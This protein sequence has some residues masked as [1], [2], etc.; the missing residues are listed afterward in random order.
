M[1][2]YYVEIDVA[3]NPA[4]AG[5]QVDPFGRTEFDA[6]L[7]ICLA[8][9]NFYLRGNWSLSANWTPAVN[10][11]C[12]LRAWD[13]PTPYRINGGTLY[14]VGDSS[15]LIWHEGIVY[16]DNFQA[17]QIAADMF[18]NCTDFSAQFGITDRNT[19]IF[20]TTGS[21]A[22]APVTN[23]CAIFNTGVGTIS[24]P[25]ATQFTNSVTNVAN[26]AALF[27]F[28]GNVASEAGSLYSQSYLPAPAWDNADL[29]AFDIAD[30]FGVGNRNGGWAFQAIWVDIRTN[31]DGGAPRTGSKG[32]PLSWA[33]YVAFTAERTNSVFRIYGERTLTV[34]ASPAIDADDTVHNGWNGNVDEGFDA[35]KIISASSTQIGFTLYDESTVFRRLAVQG[36][37]IAMNADGTGRTYDWKNCYFRSTVYSG[38]G[39]GVEGIYIST[40][41]GDIPT[42]VNFEGCTFKSPLVS[43]SN[44]SSETYFKYCLFEDSIIATSNLAQELI[45]DNCVFVGKTQAEVEARIGSGVTATFISCTFGAVLNRTLPEIT[46]I[47]S[48]SLRFSRFGLPAISSSTW[49]SDDYNHGF[50]SE[51]REGVGAFYFGIIAAVATATPSTGV[52]PLNVQFAGNADG[53]ND[54]TGEWDFGDGTV[55]DEDSPTHTYSAPGEYTWTYTLT[56]LIGNT[57]TVTGT[58]YVYD[59]DYAG[60][61]SVA[62]TERCLRY[63]IRGNQG[64]GWSFYGNENWIWPEARHGTLHIIDENDRPLQLAWNARTG[65][66]YVISNKETFQ[67]RRRQE[68]EGYEI[69]TYWEFPED[70]GT[71]DH[72][73]LESLEHHTHFQPFNPDNR[74]QTGYDNQG[75]R[76]DFEVTLKLFKDGEPSDEEVRARNIPIDGDIVFDRNVESHRI[77]LRGET[78]TSEYRMV[79]RR[80][81]YVA[82]DQQANPTDNLMSEY[83]WQEDFAEPVYHVTRGFDPYVDRATGGA[84]GG[85]AFAFGTGPDGESG[86]AF[87]FNGAEGLTFDSALN[88]DSD[89]TIIGWVGNMLSGTL[90]RMSTGNLVV[91][92]SNQP[93][94]TVEDDDDTYEKGFDWDFSG[95]KMFAVVREGNFMRLY[96][97]KELLDTFPISDF[98]SYGGVITH[99]TNDTGNISDLWVFESA[100]SANAL[101]YYY[102]DIVENSGN[103]FLPM[104]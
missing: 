25:P 86:S 73:I 57:S 91:R 28:P 10:N 32:R 76:E 94:L 104:D 42:Y 65:L 74:N 90:F 70:M 11:L 88:L 1:A 31:N 35:W 82:K 2:D 92:L 97:D 61:N 40:S 75:Y 16:C 21:Y 15:T 52:A 36:A 39:G 81:Y 102:D 83:R 99:M 71:A 79:R 87:Q 60:G 55:T 59:F 27:T 37:P 47:N 6:Q 34:S 67:D 45:F 63:A 69:S 62:F 46:D 53:D 20:N 14:D 17:R 98:N 41:G 4:S 64:R 5:T 68:Y 80:S 51:D 103:T 78:T 24:N 77:R 9:D 96:L 30:G 3:S 85:S 66:P 7:A 101:N 13:Y 33:D 49:I 54:V 58:I 44:L 18:V 100:L 93:K 50:A 12:F 8:G 22:N 38:E 56:D 48:T 29:R 26:A 23:L 84:V 89:F 19:V 72:Y 43:V 95:W